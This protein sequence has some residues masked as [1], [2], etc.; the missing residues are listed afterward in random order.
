MTTTFLNPCR[1]RRALFG[2]TLATALLAALPDAVDLVGR[3]SIPVAAAILRRAALFVGN[4]SGLMHLAGSAG[5]PTIG[6]FGPTPSAEYAPAGPRT[7]AVV[8]PSAAMEA[9]TV[10][11]VRQAVDHLME[12]TGPPGA[13]AIEL[14]PAREA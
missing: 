2:A 9:I 14:W 7:L 3:Q 10:E 8:G 12:R 5:A 4:D 1:G 11:A 6:L 13:P